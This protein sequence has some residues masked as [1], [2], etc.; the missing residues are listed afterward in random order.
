[1]REEHR[2]AARDEDQSQKTSQR[3]GQLACGAAI[4]E[5]KEQ[6]GKDRHHQP[7]REARN[8]APEEC[9]VLPQCP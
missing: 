2:N 3:I 1:M 6:A 7:G 8:Q 5:R 4:D 9:A